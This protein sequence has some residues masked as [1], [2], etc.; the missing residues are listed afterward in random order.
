VSMWRLPDRVALLV[1]NNDRKNA[2]DAV[3]QVDLDKLQ[4]V[5]KLPW[6]EF[7]GVRDLDKAGKEPPSRLDFH[8]RQLTVPGLLP[9]T[10]RLVGIRLY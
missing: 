7:V 4:L 2:R 1:F 10:G 8:K 5:P 6:Q 9:H 3:V